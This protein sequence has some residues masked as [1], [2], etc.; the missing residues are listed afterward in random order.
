MG[1]LNCPAPGRHHAIVGILVPVK[2]F[3][4]IGM[5]ALSTVLRRVER[6][7]IFEDVGRLFRR[8]K[9]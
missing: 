6:Y 9:T 5:H 4:R 1:T 2:E 8:S 7:R 3:R